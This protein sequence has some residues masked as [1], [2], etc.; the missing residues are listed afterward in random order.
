[1]WPFVTNLKIVHYNN[2]LSSIT[3]PLTRVEKIFLSFKTV[4]AKFFGKCNFDN[5]PQKSQN[6]HWVHKFQ[7]TGLVNNLNKKTEK[8]RP[9][10]RLTARCLDNVDAVR[11]SV[12]R[13]PK[14]SP[15]TL[16]TLTFTCNQFLHL[17]FGLTFLK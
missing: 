12:G 4:Q 13:S 7:D 5:S 11:D 10:E 15:K 3:M 14:N 9:G 6:H 17:S 8:L 16:S 2:H 1:M